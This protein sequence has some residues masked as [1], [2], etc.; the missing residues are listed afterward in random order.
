VLL[1]SDCVHN[2]GPDPR[3]AAGR[4]PRLDVLFD[5]RGERDSDLARGLARVGRGMV[6]PIRDHRQVAPALERIFGDG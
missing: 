5:V 6:A 2:A 1:L 3:A 4:L